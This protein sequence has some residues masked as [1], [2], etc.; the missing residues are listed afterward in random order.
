MWGLFAA[1]I[2]CSLN[3]RRECASL[4]SWI[5]R[6]RIPAPVQS[7][8]LRRDPPGPGFPGGAGLHLDLALLLLQAITATLGDY[9]LL[10][11]KLKLLRLIQ[12]LACPDGP[13]EDRPRMAP[14]RLRAAGISG[15]MIVNICSPCRHTGSTVGSF[16]SV[17]LP[18]ASLALLSLSGG[19]WGFVFFSWK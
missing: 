7:P 3:P 9:R 19:M 15:E 13:G 14:Q 6:S 2:S 1:C 4:L 8:P 18:A 17:S 11:S 5:A 16:H 12:L 10:T